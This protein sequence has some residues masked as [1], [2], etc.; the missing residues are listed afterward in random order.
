D[1]GDLW[2]L[3]GDPS[4]LGQLRR[5]LEEAGIPVES[6]EPALVATTVVPLQK[7]AD[8]RKVLRVVE[9]LEDH[10]DVQSVYANFDIPDAILEEVAAS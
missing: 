2:Q 3:T 5:A 7:E 9:A 8:A 6:A 10:D 4:S 1:E